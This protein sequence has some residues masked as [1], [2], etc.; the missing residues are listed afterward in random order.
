ME[1]IKNF[2]N[3]NKT[4][5][6]LVGI[7]GVLIIGGLGNGVWEYILKPLFS[8][9]I[10]L[11]LNLSTLGIE[12]FKDT[13]YQSIAE[14]F[15][16]KNSIQAYGLVTMLY[17]WLSMIVFTFLLKKYKNSTKKEN[18]NTN[19][20]KISLNRDL[21]MKKRLYIL[22]FLTFILFIITF[23]ENIQLRYINN[24]IVY[25]NQLINITTPYISEQEVKNFNSKFSLIKNKT[26]YEKIINDLHLILEKN[27]LELKKRNIW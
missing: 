12:S 7:I 8:F 21:G 25:Y 16:E 19:E 23:I 1:T 5:S 11:I 27:N 3:N 26:D 17:V 6:W 15:S 9:S 4:L 24:S 13:V 22:S 20:S 10:D 14:G 18:H 2:I